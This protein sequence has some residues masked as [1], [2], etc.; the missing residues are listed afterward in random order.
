MLQVDCCCPATGNDKIKNPVL[1]VDGNCPATAKRS[2]HKSLLQ[3][4]GHCPV[5]VTIRSV[6]SI[7]SG[8][9][10]QAIRSQIIVSG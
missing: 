3:V 1:Q 8:C 10:L 9:W 2:D 4:D 7:A 6:N 5:T